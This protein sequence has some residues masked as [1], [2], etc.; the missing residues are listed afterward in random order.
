MRR[1][2]KKSGKVVRGAAEKK[3]VNPKFKR[4]EQLRQWKKGVRVQSSK[5]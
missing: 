4:P 3:K 1:T 2:H 5:E